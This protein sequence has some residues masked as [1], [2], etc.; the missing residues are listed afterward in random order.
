M[1]LQESVRR[2][3][4]SVSIFLFLTLLSIVHFVLKPAFIYHSNGSYR[5]FGLGHSNKT[6]LPI[7]VCS[8][9]LA[10]LSYLA[11]LYFFTYT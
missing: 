2:N 4:L 8:I 9:V 6:V 10:I 3:K 1:R 5:E 7:W 11:V